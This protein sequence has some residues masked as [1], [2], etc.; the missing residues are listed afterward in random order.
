LR[1]N[2][3]QSLSASEISLEYE[4]V[5]PKRMYNF[6]ELEKFEGRE[7]INII[8]GFQQKIKETNQ[9]YDTI[10]NNIRKVV[11]PKDQEEEYKFNLLDKENNNLRKKLEEQLKVNFNH[12]IIMESQERIIERYNTNNFLMKNI[13]PATG[14]T[15]FT[16]GVNSPNNKRT[17]SATTK[18]SVKFRPSTGRPLTSK[19]NNILK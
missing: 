6:E 5:K 10:K 4:K 8:L 1:S 16:D 9:F 19:E 3:D 13:R 17:Y 18:N 11:P 7:L 2:V 14:L 15:G 12:K